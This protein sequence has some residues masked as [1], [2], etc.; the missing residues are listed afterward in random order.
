MKVRMIKKAPRST[1]LALGRFWSLTHALLR[2]LSASC[3]AS[4]L[5]QKRQD[6]SH[7]ELDGNHFAGIKRLSVH[8]EVT[9]GLS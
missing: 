3:L 6:G 8:Q 1:G 2:R 4:I 9:N 5:M 7:L